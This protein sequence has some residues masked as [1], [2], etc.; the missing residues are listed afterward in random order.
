MQE[1]RGS[2]FKPGESVSGTLYSTPQALP[3]K[4]ADS[5]GNVVWTVA[6]DSQFETG[7]HYADIAGAE[8]GAVSAPNNTTQFTV[9]TKAGLANTGAATGWA[10]PLILLLIAAGGGAVLLGERRQRESRL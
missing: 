2:G 5:L 3:A 1:I 10:F 8:S 7:S 9:T 6:I 4:A